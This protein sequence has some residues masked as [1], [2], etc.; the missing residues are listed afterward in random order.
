MLQQKTIYVVALLIASG[1]NALIALYS[2]Q[3]HKK[4]SEAEFSG[5]TLA[6]SVYALGYALA[7]NSTTMAGILSWARIEYLGIAAIPVLWIILAIRYTGEDRWL[8]RRLLAALL[9]VPVITLVLFYTN[10][11]HHFYY[12]SLSL[13]T[14]GPFTVLAIVKGP[15]YWVFVIYIYMSLLAGNALFLWKRRH[16]APSYHHQINIMV[17]GSLAAWAGNIVYLTGKSP[18]GLDLGPFT[19]GITGLVFGWGLL[20]FRLIDLA[21]IARDIVF[22]GM[23]DGVLVM[24]VANRIVDYNPAAQSIISD[25]SVTDIGNHAGKVLGKYPELVKHLADSTNKQIELQIAQNGGFRYYHFRLSPV[26]NRGKRLVGKT[27]IL[28]DITQHVLLRDE[29]RVLARTDNLT[30]IFNRSYFMELGQKEVEQ[31]NRYMRPIS[32]ILM[33]IDHFKDINDTH[34]HRVGDLAL[35]NIVEA[36]RSCL[37]ITDLF[38]RYGGEEFVMILPETPPDMAMVM[39]ERLRGEISAAP[40]VLDD[41]LVT[42]TASFGIAGVKK[43]NGV[44]LESLLKNADLALYQAKDAGRNRVALGGAPA[45]A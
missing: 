18:W 36:C 15:W 9:T 29:L 38:G 21:P 23:R 32:V 8:T 30:N 34:G 22:E 25:L 16:I 10:D 45:P 40:L 4:A 44:D 37:R 26:I 42:T 14:H 28:N 12:Q 2:Y 7:L 41:S 39:A 27:I 24:D 35:K 3:R 43:A 11:Y 6:I 19:V 1:I 31:A 5:L 17:A 13:A 33:D 20:R